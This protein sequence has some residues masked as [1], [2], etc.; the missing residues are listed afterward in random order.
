MKYKYIALLLSLVLTTTLMAQKPKNVQ[1]TAEGL[2]DE[3]LEYINNSTNDKDRQKENTK[4]LKDFK[5]AYNNFDSRLQERLVGVYSYAVKA[6]MKGT[7]E[8]SGLT[9]MLT[10]IATTPSGGDGVADAYS[11]APNLEGFVASLEAFAKRGAK[12]KIFRNANDLEKGKRKQKASRLER[13]YM[14][15]KT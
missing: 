10:T 4:I 6:K 11:N 9:Q 12:A 7:P 2:P 15:I 14:E 3:L 13:V 5:T 8:M 1:F